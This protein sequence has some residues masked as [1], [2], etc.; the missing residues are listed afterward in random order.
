MAKKKIIRRKG[1]SKIGR[2][3]G[4]S[5]STKATEISEA[6]IKELKGNTN[7]AERLWDGNKKVRA[8]K[9]KA[10]GANILEG[11]PAD[12]KLQKS[13]PAKKVRKGEG[14]AVTDL[15]QPAAGSLGKT[16]DD[17]DTNIRSSK[18]AAKKANEFDKALSKKQK[19]LETYETKR[20]SLKGVDKIKFIAENQTRIKSLKASIKDMKSRGGPGGQST[21]RYKKK[22]GG[23]IIKRKSPGK[24]TSPKVKKIMQDLDWTKGL[25]DDQIREMISGP[26]SDGRRRAKVKKKPSKVRK[27]KAGGPVV[28]KRGGG[29]TRQGLSPAEEARSGTMSQAKRKRYMKKG[30]I[31]KFNEGGVISG[32]I[33]SK[34]VIDYIYKM[35][36]RP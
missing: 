5:P 10:G 12:K 20:D 23:P 8:A 16:A 28:K 32:K 34:N 3:I 36:K 18:V 7:S 9:R 14:K 25:T 13:S 26:H 22:A 1:G 27:A 21:I 17:A 30:G 29:M 35:H 15:K 6:T 31:V 33:P 11:G 2:K 4:F 19:Q 24:T